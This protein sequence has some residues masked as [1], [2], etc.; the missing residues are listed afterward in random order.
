M[1]TFFSINGVCTLIMYSNRDYVFGGMHWSVYFF[2][3]I[4]LKGFFY[5]IAPIINK[6]WQRYALSECSFVMCQVLIHISSIAFELVILLT[7][8]QIIDK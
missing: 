3:S 8:A 7:H 4:F 5:I 6:P 2:S 1:T